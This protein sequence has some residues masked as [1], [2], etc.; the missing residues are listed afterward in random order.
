M[1]VFWLVPCEIRGQDDSWGLSSLG[2]SSWPV[3]KGLTMD[4][5]MASVPEGPTTARDELYRLCP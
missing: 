4:M 5:S 3:L 1:A 2:P